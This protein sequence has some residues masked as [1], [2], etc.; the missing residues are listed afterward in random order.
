MSY[1]FITKSDEF[2]DEDKAKLLGKNAQA[3]YRFPDF[4]EIKPIKHML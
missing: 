3:F 1:D 2:D 4:D